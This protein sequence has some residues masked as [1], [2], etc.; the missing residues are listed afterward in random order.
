MEFGIFYGVSRQ[1]KAGRAIRYIFLGLEKSL[2]KDA[3]AIPN[4][5]C[6]H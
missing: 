3:A 1:K 6:Y 5:I 2:K 4:T